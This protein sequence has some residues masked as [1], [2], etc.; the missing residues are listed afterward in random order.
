MKTIA[1]EDLLNMKFKYDDLEYHVGAVC[2]LNEPL[3]EAIKR[4]EEKQ[5]EIIDWINRNEDH[6]E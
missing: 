3:I 4:L 1:Q 6:K 5:N 2:D